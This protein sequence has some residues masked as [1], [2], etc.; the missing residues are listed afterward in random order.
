MDVEK[1]VVCQE[2]KNEALSNCKSG[3]TSFI[4]YAKQSKKT[5]LENH[6]ETIKIGRKTNQN[7]PPVK[8]HRSCQRNMW[9]DTYKDER[10]EAEA[11]TV[12]KSKTATRSSLDQFDWK[13]NCMFCGKTCKID[14]KHPERVHDVHRCE[15]KGYRDVVLEQCQLIDDEEARVIGHRVRSCSDFVAAEARYHTSCRGQFNLKVKTKSSASKKGR[16]CKEADGFEALCEWMETEG[17]LHTLENLQNQLKVITG[18]E[19]V[20]CTRSIKRKLQEKYGSDI[21]LNEVST[22]QL[23]LNRKMADLRWKS[24]QIV[25]PM[26]LQ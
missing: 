18:S 8:Y 9:N 20:Y 15:Y 6:L 2:D 22:D 5:S 4:E 21:S 12:K 19:D 24:D 10:D 7:V 25:L 3:I 14:E 11:P 23:E 13:T 17:E 16:P 1:C 26:P